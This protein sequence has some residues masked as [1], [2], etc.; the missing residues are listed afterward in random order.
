MSDC[1]IGKV[2]LGSL[3]RWMLMVGE[4]L[5]ERR[6]VEVAARVKISVV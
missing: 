2:P 6:A 1:A 5:P 3:V 4:P